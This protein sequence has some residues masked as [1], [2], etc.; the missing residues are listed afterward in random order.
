MR[1][2]SAR[3]KFVNPISFWAY[4]SDVHATASSPAEARKAR[5]N[6]VPS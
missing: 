5:L 3:S 6:T 1:A 2:N 4:C